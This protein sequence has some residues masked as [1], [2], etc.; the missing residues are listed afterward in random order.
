MSLSI[1]TLNTFLTMSMNTFLRQT[2]VYNKTIVRSKHNDNPV[3]D[4][5]TSFS[6]DDFNACR[7]VAFRLGLVKY[8]FESLRRLIE[9][10]YNNVNHVV[11]RKDATS[12]FAI[13]EIREIWE[14]FEETRDYDYI[15]ELE[16]ILA[17]FGVF[18]ETVKNCPYNYRDQICE[19]DSM[20]DGVPIGDYLEAKSRMKM[21]DFN[22]IYT[23]YA[24][25]EF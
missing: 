8:C 10:A 21:P 4:I 23:Y 12:C 5:E 11:V 13:S 9:T 14:S 2:S 25:D 1:K 15:E 18:L 17:Y 7:S 20:A 24:E 22:E 3:D 19:T 16:N 6:F